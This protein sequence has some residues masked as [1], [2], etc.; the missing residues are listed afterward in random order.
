M[1]PFATA[2]GPV[3]NF[4][5]PTQSQTV[6]V[7]H[8]VRRKTQ[9]GKG[10]AATENSQPTQNEASGSRNYDRWDKKSGS[11]GATPEGCLV[12]W[13]AEEGNWKRWKDAKSTCHKDK[14]CIDI[15][16][17][18]K[19]NGFPERTKDSIQSKIRLIEDSFKKALTWINSTGAGADS[20]D[21]DDNGDGRTAYQREVEKRCKFY[22]ILLTSFGQRG[23]MIP[24]RIYTSIEAK[25][26]RQAEHDLL[27]ALG[28]KKWD[29]EEDDE[30]DNDQ[31]GNLE[32]DD[33]DD[34]DSDDLEESEKERKSAQ[35]GKQREK[36]AHTGGSNKSRPNTGAFKSEDIMRYL[37]V[38]SQT[39]A[40][41]LEL[42]KK[43]LRLESRK[44]RAEGIAALVKA[45]LSLTEAKAAW[46]ENESD[47]E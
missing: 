14:C 2:E 40:L 47:S 5:Q 1:P 15:N 36:L 4:A 28:L 31:G 30:A 27:C 26:N 9:Q 33:D 24:K 23:S 25:D 3:V 44:A 8:S 20:L 39:E 37:S 35:K 13:L 18:L 10:K 41:R 6:A 43:K 34:G 19:D 38:K 16:Q 42:D 11:D 21:A 45:G 12:D 46:T 22:D 17:H 7:S 32:A 29:L